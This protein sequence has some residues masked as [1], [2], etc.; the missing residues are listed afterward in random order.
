MTGM[1]RFGKHP[2]GIALLAMAMMGLTG[3][4]A[5]QTEYSGLKITKTPDQKVVSAG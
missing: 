4:A 3:F 2:A 1:T 5:A